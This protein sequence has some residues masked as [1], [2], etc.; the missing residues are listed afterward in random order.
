MILDIYTIG[1]FL[2]FIIIVIVVFFRV[3]NKIKKNKI[4]EKRPPDDHY[5]LY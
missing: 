1:I 4:K 5:P 2:F 3:K